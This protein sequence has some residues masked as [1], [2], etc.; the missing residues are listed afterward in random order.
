V[1]HDRSN[2]DAAERDRPQR[3]PQVSEEGMPLAPS[4]CAAPF[5][6]MNL[7]TFQCHSPLS[8]MCR[9]A[10]YSS[11]DA[12]ASAKLTEETE[13]FAELSQCIS[14]LVRPQCR[15]SPIQRSRRRP[16]DNAAAQCRRH[17][18]LHLAMIQAIGVTSFISIG[19]LSACRCR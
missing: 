3:R 6:P 13:F 16:R 11:F 7:G 19:Q 15:T 5:S 2:D 1:S 17:C 18:D 8:S 4:H 14:G 9:T 10:L 12:D